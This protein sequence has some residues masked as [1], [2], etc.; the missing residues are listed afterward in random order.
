MGPAALVVRGVNFDHAALVADLERDE[1]RRRFVYRDT[2]T[3]PTIGVGHL[4]SLG[5]RDSEIDLIL[6]N[7]IA[8]AVADLDNHLPWWRTL[9]PVRQRVIANMAFNLGVP[10]LMMF[11]RMLAAVRSQ[12]WATAADEMGNSK[13]AVQVG[14]RA[15]RLQAMMRTGAEP[16]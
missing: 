8:D 13:W 15:V 3:N 16:S 9:D 5:L 10:R 1:G 11:R 12:L 7:D 14:E 2:L 6:R 4:L